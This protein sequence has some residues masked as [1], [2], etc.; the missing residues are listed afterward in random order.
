MP[1][2]TPHSTYSHRLA[3]HRRTIARSVAAEG[4]LA[5]IRLFLFVVAVALAWPALFADRLPWWVV[6]LPVAAF[7]PV[8]VWHSRLIQRRERVER[9]AA[10]Y[11]RGLDRLDDRWA[12][13]G[14][15]GE[16]FRQ[17]DHP[18]ADDLDLFGRGSLFELLSIAGSGAGERTLAGWLLVGADPET[19]RRR[20]A[21]VAELRPMLDLRERLVVAG[22]DVRAGVDPRQLVSWVGEP[23]VL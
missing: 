18:Y 16:S 7:L 9:A 11:R 2:V 6:L 14:S 17:P 23:A 21:A 15:A 20:P 12:G 5:W 13:G 1:A 19:V 10:F 4:R 3:A 22:A 8:V